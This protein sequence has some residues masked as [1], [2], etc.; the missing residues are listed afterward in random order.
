MPRD[1]NLEYPLLYRLAQ[2]LMGAGDS[3][4]Q[5]GT[6]LQKQSAAASDVLESQGRQ[7]L[8]TDVLAERRREAAL[9]DQRRR[10]SSSFIAALGK[11]TQAGQALVD[12]GESASDLEPD[13]YKFALADLTKRPEPLEFASGDLGIFNKRTGEVK[14]PKPEKPAPPEFTSGDLGIFNKTTGEIKT[15]KPE[16]PEKPQRAASIGA[17]VTAALAE[18]GADPETATP[19]QIKT[20]RKMV[21][22][23][24]VE[25]S[26]Q[27]GAGRALGPQPTT[28]EERMRTA[29]GE[30]ALQL[31]QRAMATLDKNPDWVG[32]PYGLQ[33]IWR[34]VQ[35]RLGTAP[36]GFAEFQADILEVYG[37]YARRIAGAAL[38]P[39]EKKTYLA[40]LPDIGRDSTQE[41]MAKL[42]SM[43]ERIRTIDAAIERAR[44]GT[45]A[46]RLGTAAPAATPSSTQ[47]G[48]TA[49]D[50][51]KKRGY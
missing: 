6:G 3:L 19:D 7:D 23:G 48:G 41:F 10:T 13:A 38:T 8:Q 51:L 21:Q 33:G 50:Y 40:Y 2:F 17:E 32:G 12:L 29:E 20:A 18:L 34:N 26:V 49:E 4:G 1:P 46:P 35:A 47:P 39:T 36:E 24:R 31:S 5:Y 15:P 22:E 37:T 9:K 45:A 11:G 25:V 30:R 43:P 44:L 27:Q 42:R 14:V 28:A 16:K